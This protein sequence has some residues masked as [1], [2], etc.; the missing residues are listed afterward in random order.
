MF[1][2]VQ[3]CARF[4]IAGQEAELLQTFYIF[5]SVTLWTFN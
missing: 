1:L 5:L 4:T 3:S 2:S